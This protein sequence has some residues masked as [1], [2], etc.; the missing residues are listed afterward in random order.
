[1]LKSTVQES[2]WPATSLSRKLSEKLEL[3]VLKTLST[4]SPLV[5]PT[6]RLLTDSSGPS[7][8]T[9]PEVDMLLKE[10]ISTLVVIGETENTLSMILSLECYD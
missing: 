6:S 9:L 3:P 4:K 7:N 1:M 2:P 8:L 5:D 10:K